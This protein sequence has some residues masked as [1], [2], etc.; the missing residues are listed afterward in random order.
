MC[1]SMSFMMNVVWNIIVFP[2][3][4]ERTTPSNFFEE[5]VIVTQGKDN[6]HP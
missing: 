6:L 2:T 4:Q 5:M 1:V 3:D